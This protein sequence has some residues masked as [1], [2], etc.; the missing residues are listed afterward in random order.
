LKEQNMRKY[1]RNPHRG[2]LKAPRWPTGYTHAATR[3]A[4]A[5]PSTRA[6][7]ERTWEIADIDGNN[8]RT[9]TLSAYRA[10]LDERKVYTAAIAAAM[11]RGDLAGCAAAQAAMRARFAR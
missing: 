9:T 8:K 10:E 3:A 5:P 6:T 1:S 2:A 7:G 11:R 4:S